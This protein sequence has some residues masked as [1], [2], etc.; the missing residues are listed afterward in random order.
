M[1]KTEIGKKAEDMAARY[2]L[3]KGYIILKRNWRYKKA[4]I[5]IIAKQDSVLVFVEVKYRSYEHFGA[6]E[7]AVDKKKESLLLDA[8]AAFAEEIN[9]DW[10]V[11]FDIISL[12]KKGMEFQIEHFEDA[13][14]PMN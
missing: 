13:F 9:H 6:P 14:F 5:D 12:L 7:N 10:A 11:R 2:L 1:N 3:S 4:E 8:G